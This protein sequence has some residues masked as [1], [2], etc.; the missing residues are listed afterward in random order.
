MIET[1]SDIQV[2]DVDDNPIALLGYGDGDVTP[3]AQW[4]KE[5]MTKNEIHLFFNYT[6]L[7]ESYF[8]RGCYINTSYKEGRF[9]L[10]SAP[11]KPSYNTS[12]GGLQYELIFEAFE[13]LWQDCPMFYS[14]QNASEV[15]W[16]LTGTPSQFL[17]IGIDA[18]NTQFGSNWKIGK[19]PDMEPILIEFDS[20]FVFD[21]FT[22][23]AEAFG[24]EWYA[25]YDNESVNFVDSYEF[26]YHITLEREK[27]LIELTVSNENNEDYCNR[28]IV[29][30]ST[31]NI[32]SN[33]RSTGSN[34]IVDALIQK[35]LRMP[36]DVG[37]YLDAFPNMKATQI[38]PK[39]KKF[40][41]IFPKRIGTITGIRTETTKN[42]DGVEMTVFFFKDSGLTFSEDYLMVGL[43]L[44]AHFETGNLIGRDLELTYHPKT[45]E[46]EITNDQDNPDL[47]IPNDIFCPSEGDEYVLYNFNI[48]LVGDQYIP[49]AEQALKV[50]AEKYFTSILEDNATY[51]CPVNPYENK[52]SGL[53]F[54]IGQRVK[55]VSLILK[56]K[57]KNS[58]VRGFEKTIDTH[59]VTYTVGDKPSYSRRKTIENTVESNKEIADMQYLEAM[60]AVKN[61]ARTVKGMRYIREALENYTSIEN[62][63]VLT[64]TII[65]GAIFGGEWQA[66][67]GING[68]GGGTDD[69]AFWAGGT[70]DQAVNLV[71]NPDATS[72]VAQI[73]ITHGGGIIANNAYIKGKINAKEG[74]IGGMK[75]S[76]ESLTNEG[77]NNDAYII[78][79]ND[80]SKTFAGIGGNI[81]P[82]SSGGISAVARFENNRINTDVIAPDNIA[83]LVSASGSHNKNTAIMMN[84]GYLSGLALIPLQVDSNETLVNRDVWVSCYNTSNITIT[85]PTKPEKGKVFYLRQINS[86]GFTIVGKSSTE[87]YQIHTASGT[88]V[89]SMDFSSQGGTAMMFFDGQ[90]WCYS[91]MG[92]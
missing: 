48:S 6:E 64:S 77:F 59:I 2:Y 26:G 70:L 89:D 65:L 8:N 25:D 5:L 79:R 38:D 12:T 30:G 52:N 33:Y 13:M 3:A 76:G 81:L 60:K 58:R 90:F 74:F 45:Q 15:E 24:L 78:L 41:D 83:L 7:L 1:G 21:G 22:K 66:N 86:S 61:T 19:C 20:E 39:V 57:F 11:K 23:V 46:F 32:P 28:L 84:G 63:L 37:D 16:K 85:L 68:V 72:D 69:V 9:W 92:R 88:I 56:N 29:F 71:A 10:R 67:A 14:Y 91:Y 49:E 36:V 73:V 31:R 17:Q 35:R 44:S 53:D 34:D 43:N 40:D 51:T 18:I 55:L 62:G 80:L 54:D 27:E 75:I 82:A 47:I 4:L 42:D 87:S 50:E